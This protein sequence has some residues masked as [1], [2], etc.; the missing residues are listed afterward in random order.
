MYSRTLDLRRYIQLAVP[1]GEPSQALN[2]QQSCVPR[3]A[4]R[5][6]P[7]Q[8]LVELGTLIRHDPAILR[9]KSD[10]LRSTL[11]TMHV[12]AY[13]HDCVETC[14]FHHP[15]IQK[16]SSSPP[17]CTPSTVIERACPTN[18]STK[19]AERTSLDLRCLGEEGLPLRVD[20]LEYLRAAVSTQY[21]VR[22]LWA[23][24]VY[25]SP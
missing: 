6:S 24:R 14:V 21:V 22:D 17:A 12:Q 10:P 9:I 2:D 18:P 11:P 13:D 23:P 25:H 3:K 16:Y 1:P 7:T 8:V 4:S 15:C 19:R 5:I 20:I